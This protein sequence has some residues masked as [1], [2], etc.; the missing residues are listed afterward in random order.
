M[1]SDLSN[2]TATA[3]MQE[4]PSAVPSLNACAVPTLVAD[5]KKLIELKYPKL[6]GRFN[7]AFNG[8]P[9]DM[10]I[11][12]AVDLIAGDVAG[13]L[14]AMPDNFKTSNH[15]ISRPKFGLSYILQ[16]E[17]VRAVLGGEYCDIKNTHIERAFEALKKDV[18]IPSEK[19]EKEMN[20]STAVSDAAAVETVDAMTTG[21]DDDDVQATI[22]KMAIKIAELEASN[23]FL[24]DSLINVMN[25]QYG[26]TVSN[27]VKGLLGSF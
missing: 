6:H 20:D 10:P 23:K 12:E 26:D 13:W 18:V 22:S 4:D 5:A 16:H 2:T 7:F 25:D 27:L 9:D 17:D 1:D 19:K 21:D 14:A 11:K 24:A 3:N 8:L 15:A